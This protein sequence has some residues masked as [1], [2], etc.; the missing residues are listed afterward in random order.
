MLETDLSIRTIASK[1]ENVHTDKLEKHSFE[2]FGQDGFTF[3][4]FLDIINP[5]Q[6]IPLVSTIYRKITGDLI[7]PASKIAGSALYGGPIG[8]VTSLFDVMIENST[9][10]DVVEHALEISNHQDKKF[11]KIR[12]VNQNKTTNETTMT[13][14]YWPQLAAEKVPFEQKD[15]GI[16]NGDWNNSFGSKRNTSNLASQSVLLRK[17]QAGIN[18]EEQTKANET[19]RHNQTTKAYNSISHLIKYR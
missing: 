14:N 10:R 13:I 7:D 12:E 6:H 3:L 18:I 9:G 2:P 15:Y 5:L 16:T 4:D 11:E 1:S 17:I 8:A 19:V